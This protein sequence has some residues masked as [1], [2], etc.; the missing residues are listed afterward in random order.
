MHHTSKP[1]SPFPRTPCLCASLLFPYPIAV[2]LEGDSPVVIDS[3]AMVQIMDS[4]LKSSVLLHLLS[5]PTEITRL[6]K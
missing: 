5:C 1:P 2:Y 4:T 6:K 3:V